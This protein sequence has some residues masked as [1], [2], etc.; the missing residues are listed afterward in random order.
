MFVLGRK[1]SYDGPGRS[2]NIRVLCR[3]NVVTSSPRHRQKPTDRPY[4]HIEHRDYSMS[5][6]TFSF[7][8]V[9]AP[10]GQSLRF[11]SGD[12]NAT[13]RKNRK[14]AW[15]IAFGHAYLVP[16]NPFSA[17][18]SSRRGRALFF[19]T[20]NDPNPVATTTTTPGDGDGENGIPIGPGSIFL[21][22]PQHCSSKG[23]TFVL[24]IK[25]VCLI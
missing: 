13:R 18:S 7:R 17:K 16:T 12:D 15:R 9:S 21:S 24:K 6:A 25:N 1:A 10:S 14:L 23:S 11:A 5:A 8:V 20:Q 4:G 3:R 2:R 22:F 19:D